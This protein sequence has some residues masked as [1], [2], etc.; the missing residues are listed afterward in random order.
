MEGVR[1]GCQ[2]CLSKFEKVCH[3]KNHMYS[4]EHL[5]KSTDVFKQDIFRS[6]VQ[7]PLVAVAGKRYKPDPRQPITGL[8]LCFSRETETSFY[9][10]H[11]CEE[12]H[13]LNN[14]LFHLSS[15]DHCA[16]YFSYKNPNVL[17]FSWIPT[18][19]VDK[20]LRR[21]NKRELN[22]RSR[23]QLQMLDLPGKVFKPL[24][25]KTYHEVMR[26]LGENEKLLDSL[27]AVKPQRT[28]LQT[29]QRD[30]SR[31]HP[32]LGTQHLV[33]IVCVG[34]PEKKHYLCTLCHLTLTGHAVIKH[35]LSFDHIFCYFKVWHPSTLLAKE[36]YKEY[37]CHFASMMLDFAKQTENIHAAINT[38]MKQVRLEAGKFTAMRLTCYADALKELESMRKENQESSLVTSVKP[39][40]KLDH[41]PS[42]VFRGL[43]YKDP[44]LPVTNVGSGSY[45]LHCQNCS[46]GFENMFH[47]CTH[48]SNYKHKQ[49]LKKFF[50]GDGCSDKP[51][52]KPS[53]GL[54]EKALKNPKENKPLVGVS[55]VVTC[56]CSEVHKEPLYVCF[57]CQDCF[58]ESALEQH[59]DSQRH[60]IHTSL[61]QNPWRLTLAWENCVDLKA[62]RSIAWEEEK[63]KPDQMTL[64]VV[65]MPK[66]MFE[67]L[68][69]IGY[70]K[71][72][73][74]L[75]LQHSIIKRDV[76]P[77]ET[78]SKL[79]END[80]FPLLGR[81]FLVMHN[82][83]IQGQLPTKGF[84]C[85]LCERKLSDDEFYAHEFSR[86]HIA[87]FIERFH[88]GSLDSNPDE[89][90]F[91]D[92]AKQ[93]ARY[94][95]I[96]HVQEVQLSQPVRET[97]TY[98]EALSILTSA[99]R[100]SGNAN[101]NPQINPKM[102]LV[103]R[104]KRKAVE[105]D[106]V[107]DGGETTLEQT[108]GVCAKVTDS[109]CPK[110]GE[111]GDNKETVPSCGKE[112]L[113]IKEEFL[114]T[115]SDEVNQ[116]ETRLVIKEE[117]IEKP[118]TT[119][120][121][122]KAV[123]NGQNTNEKEQSERSKCVL[124]Q[125]RN[126]SQTDTCPVDDGEQEIGNKR[127]RL[128]PKTDP[129]NML[130]STQMEVN[131]PDEGK[132]GKPKDQTANN[133]ASSE[134]DLQQVAHLWQYVKRKIRE[135]VVGLD[136][137]IECNC[138]ELAPIYLCEC[139][140]LKILEEDIISHVTG[141]DHQRMYLKL[142]QETRGETVRHSAALS[143]QE[144]G[145]GSAQVVELDYL[146]YNKVFKQDFD[147]ALSSIQPVATSVPLQAQHPVCSMED[148][149]QMLVID[150]SG[151]SSVTTL[152]STM[153]ETTSNTTRALPKSNDPQIRASNSP[154]A[155]KSTAPTCQLHPALSRATTANTVSRE[156]ATKCTAT[157]SASPAATSEASCTTQSRSRAATLVRAVSLESG[158]SSQT[159]STA[160]LEAACR[161]L[162]K[163]VAGPRTTEALLRNV[164]RPDASYQTVGL[165]QLIKVS[166]GQKKQVYCRLCSIRLLKSEHT[167]SITHQFNYVRMKFPQWS[168]KPSELLNELPNKVA[169][170]AEDEKKGGSIP[171]PRLVVTIDVYKE[172]A[173]LP[174]EKALER[175]KA[176]LE[177]GAGVTSPTTANPVPVL[178]LEFPGASQSD[179]WSPVDDIESSFKEGSLAVGRV[180]R[181]QSLES[182]EPEA[183]DQ[184]LDRL[185]S[186]L[187]KN[188]PVS[189][190]LIQDVAV[191][192]NM[193]PQTHVASKETPE[194][195]QQQERSHPE[196]QEARK[197][198]EVS[199][200]TSP[201]N[202][203]VL[204]KIRIGE[205][206]EGSSHLSSYLKVMGSD[207]EPVIGLG[208]VWECRFVSEVQGLSRSPFFLCESCSVTL[209]N[210]EICQHMVSTDHRV[211]YIMSQ[212]P[213][214]L[215]FWPE[216]YPPEY[217]DLTLENWMKLDILNGIAQMLSEGERYHKT[218]AQSILLGVDL[219]ERVLTA[220]FS[221]ALQILKNIKREHK[222][223]V[224]CPSICDPQ[225]KGQL[226]D[227]QHSPEESLP[228]E[229]QQRSDEP[230][231]QD[232]LHGVKQSGVFSHLDVTRVSPKANSVSP[233][234]S[235]DPRLRHREQPNPG[236]AVSLQQRP[237]PELPGKRA[238]AHSE[239]TSSSVV[240]P[241]TTQ[242]LPT[243]SRDQSIPIKKRPAVECIGSLI[244]S[245]TNNPNITDPFPAKCKLSYAAL[246]PIIEPSVSQST[247]VN[248]LPLPPQ[249]KDPETVSYEQDIP[250]VDQATFDHIMALFRER[251]SKGN[252]LP[253][254]SAPV[255]GEST[256]SC[257]APA[258]AVGTKSPLA[259]PTDQACMNA[260]T[261]T[262]QSTPG[263][264]DC[265]AVSR[266][267]GNT[268]RPED[269]GPG[270]DQLP[271]NAIV[272]VRSEQPGHQVVGG[273]N[274][275][276]FT[277]LN[278]GDLIT[279]CFSSVA[280]ISP[281]DA[282][283]RCGQYN[284]MAYVA[285]TPSGYFSSGAAGS[286]TTP[287]YCPAQTGRSFQCEGYP[288]GELY[289]PSQSQATQETTSQ[290]LQ[291]FGNGLATRMAPQWVRL[292]MHQQQLVQQQQRIL[293]QQLGQ[294]QQLT[295]QELTQQR[296]A[297]W[298]A[299]NGKVTNEA[300]YTGA[301]AAFTPPA[302]PSFSDYDYRVTEQASGLPQPSRF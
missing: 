244:R 204:S 118:T 155:S 89:E 299:S 157:I 217:P 39:G 13:Q 44:R 260:Q 113:K 145:F 206:T 173:D 279:P 43:W 22:E 242:T 10:C 201:L 289:F 25:M 273:I 226:P 9:L 165:N 300:A 114:G 193:N 47:Y 61:Y 170:L 80:R 207:R 100:K 150:D 111:M 280:E 258:K 184:I 291:S 197:V 4:L 298:A 205:C 213:D 20:M 125:K 276:N 236:P 270:A 285:D 172:L 36:S 296:C 57:A 73:K 98:S 87:T 160:A 252:V 92:L 247:S 88:P 166:C 37:S 117:K 277:K 194:W 83:C 255:K 41:L 30:P 183:D 254:T 72:M 6:M 140:S 294:Q 225:Q 55:L 142:A 50:G 93:A 86:G 103:P 65:D 32:L 58:T 14:I 234:C 115:S 268:A 64:K 59:F 223:S 241:P 290:S 146:T 302:N 78:Y 70:L 212:H 5:Q 34:Q 63:L 19:K 253:C 74:C 141:V 3:I 143:E 104:P 147:S 297:A 95:P 21:L 138:D 271:I 239:T 38:D 120:P 81:Q 295:Q 68:G 227:D 45:K 174:A 186:L 119:G 122:G 287:G 48:L 231:V 195:R 243:S 29:Y 42:T 121:S 40:D 281:S 263:P 261:S 218:D 188:E 283:G 97:C 266:S 151:D 250:V 240:C 178:R 136:S 286:Y 148:D 267:P 11:I 18:Q 132:S 202:P 164:K 71:L 282:S 216:N 123:E 84:L 17:K 107:R 79:K 272:S 169:Q 209:P 181:A 112:L 116:S 102:K 185:H 76:P 131:T 105:K 230:I 171:F 101:L 77:C 196:T 233:V 67:K 144:H 24:K 96:S 23:G 156:S 162:L 246:Q 108:V 124:A 228:M 220:S 7:F 187:N 238:E 179:T 237:I 69:A 126:I 159:G 75:E 214:L 110:G 154:D 256:N 133:K 248:L 8:S 198:L 91:L 130:I 1:F 275:E 52:W 90:T 292:G 203:V 264:V 35:V 200:K 224:C 161:T 215:Y 274:K 49:M 46:V 175:L 12:K 177:R 153:T 28:T 167:C 221:E 232:N 219:Y 249:D 127:Q 85:L 210:R 182:S 109:L 235:A 27:E 134:A 26:A 62:L 82:N 229:A 191:A 293:Q 284:R 33:E 99:N 158:S 60:L 257:A 56:V 168:C 262:S 66:T 176:T 53:L 31:E 199:L 211:N 222:L 288:A 54:Y 192:K 245:S 265:A 94:H 251:Q 129:Q 128:T 269:Q 208:F 2:V 15:V 190:P 259:S 137:L 106:K 149:P 163:S 301:A 16:N 51:E 180:I 189:N 139:C 135:P 278:R 152:M